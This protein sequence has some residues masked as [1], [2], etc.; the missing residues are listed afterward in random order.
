MAPVLLLLPLALQPTVGFGLSNNILPFFPICH[1]LSP[2][3]HSQHLNI[4]FYFLFPSFPGSSL[5]VLEWRSF[6]ASYP[7]PFSLGDITSLSFA[8][9]PFY[10]I[11]SFCNDSSYINIK[12]KNIWL[13]DCKNCEWLHDDWL[14]NGCTLDVFP[15][16]VNTQT[17]H[18]NCTTKIT[19]TYILLVSS[20]ARVNKIV[21]HLLEPSLWKSSTA[22]STQTWGCHYS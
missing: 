7:P 9:Y 22:H 21:T 5:P 8:F 2:S 1:Q 15:T 11:F 14:N 16:I 13:Y 6:C 18:W 19:Q 3:S 12:C 4:S 10:Y 20:E 17:D